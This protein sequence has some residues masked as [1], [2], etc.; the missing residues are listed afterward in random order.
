M[1][2]QSILATVLD[3]LATNLNYAESDYF[4]LCGDYSQK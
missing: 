4:A 2:S 1:A 3:K